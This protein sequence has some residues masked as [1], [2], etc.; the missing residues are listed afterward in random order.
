MCTTHA[1]ADETTYV[2]L[3]HTLEPEMRS[4]SA[5]LQIWR[6]KMYDTRARQRSHIQPAASP[7]PSARRL[8][9]PPTIGSAALAGGKPVK[10]NQNLIKH[11]LKI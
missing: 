7:S 6:A 1:P 2:Y 11:L 10:T 4:C 3:A 5:M 9:P 8:Q